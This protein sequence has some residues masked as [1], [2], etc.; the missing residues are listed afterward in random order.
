MGCGASAETAILKKLAK[1][2]KE[3]QMNITI[4]P[5]IKAVSDQGQTFAELAVFYGSSEDLKA[6]IAA[7]VEN[8][9]SPKLIMDLV[10]QDRLESED[11]K[12]KIQVLIDKG[13]DPNRSYEGKTLLGWA[14]TGARPELVE[15]MEKLG[16]SVWVARPIDD[17]LRDL[18]KSAKECMSNITIEPDIKAV[19]DQGQT[20]AEV[21]ASFGS[22]ADLH[23]VI[24]AGA[25]KWDSPTLILDLVRAADA[26]E[27]ESR[28]GKIQVLIDAGVDPNSS[29]EGKTLLG[30]AKGVQWLDPS[31]RSDLVEWME[32]RGFKE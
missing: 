4:E 1:S 26:L 31:A 22:P 8:W 12:A 17:V 21:A 11:Q 2:A 7:G 13:V 10:R 15:W 5:D 30:W 23:A 32:K 16:F 27:N 29:Y 6:V 14:K 28:K 3:G 18:A 9:D 25:E 24:A 20:F 19:S